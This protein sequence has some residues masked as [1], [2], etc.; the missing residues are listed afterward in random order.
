MSERK[1][2]AHIGLV[3]AVPGRLGGSFFF[4]FVMRGIILLPALSFNPIPQRGRVDVYWVEAKCISLT[5]I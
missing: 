4:H 2:A 5:S 1:K 3:L